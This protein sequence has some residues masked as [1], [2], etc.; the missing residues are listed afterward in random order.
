MGKNNAKQT[1][2]Y[3]L[4]LALNWVEFE[5]ETFDTW[6]SKTLGKNTEITHSTK[7]KVEHHCSSS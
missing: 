4:W 2:F 7:W 3:I 1:E 6:T 5:F